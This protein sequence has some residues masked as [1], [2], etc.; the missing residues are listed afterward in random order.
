MRASVDIP[1][2]TVYP[3]D[4]PN[5]QSTPAFASASSLP[6]CGGYPWPCVNNLGWTPLPLGTRRRPRQPHGLAS[7]RDA[8]AA[9][10]APRAGGRL[11]DLNAG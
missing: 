2:H 6:P 1:P 4:M 8:F 7:W 9:P 5:T 11:W 10:A 3:V